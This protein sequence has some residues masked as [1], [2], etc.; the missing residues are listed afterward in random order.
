MDWSCILNES[1]TNKTYA[2]FVHV[3]SDIYNKAFPKTR[4]KIKYYHRKP[5]LTE[6][7]K[8]SI[9]QKNKLFKL[10]KK[11]PVADSIVKYKTYR[12]TLYKLLKRWEK[13]YYQDRFSGY[14]DNMQKTW[15]VMKRILNKSRGCVSRS[16]LKHDNETIADDYSIAN[17][18]NNFFVNVSSDLANRIPDH[19]SL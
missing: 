3:Y 16:I 12:S 5:W 4:A 19:F 7:L 2:M 11:Y 14:R 18:F 6:V 8:I 10:S 17:T 9:R 1:D 13:M 15:S